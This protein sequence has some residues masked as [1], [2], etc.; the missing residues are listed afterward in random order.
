[1]INEIYEFW[2]W[3]GWGGFYLQRSLSAQV[4]GVQMPTLTEEK[5]QFLQW[6]SQEV[7]LII[8]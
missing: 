4:M 3:A 7:S 1:M 8:I 6:G 2:L 5:S